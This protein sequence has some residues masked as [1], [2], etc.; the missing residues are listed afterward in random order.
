MQLADFP[1]MG[2]APVPGYL[3]QTDDG[4]KVSATR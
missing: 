3:V 4:A 1:T 2:D